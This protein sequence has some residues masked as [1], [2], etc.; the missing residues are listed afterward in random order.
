MESRA[1][2]LGHPIHPM[3]IVLP[4]GLFIAAVVFDAVYPWRGSL[5]L[6]TAAYWNIAGGIVGGLLAA[7]FGLVDWLAIPPVRE[8]SESGC[9]TAAPTSLSC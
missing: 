6:A 2:L 7:M 8:Q 1:K 9:C 5:P 4:F 3:L